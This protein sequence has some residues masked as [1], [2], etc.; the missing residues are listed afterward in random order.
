MLIKW[1]VLIESPVY[2]TGHIYPPCEYCCGRVCTIH[3][4][5]GPASTATKGLISNDA[6]CD[7]DTVF[8]DTGKYMQIFTLYLIGFILA[9]YHRHANQVVFVCSFVHSISFNFCVGSFFLQKVQRMIYMAAFPINSLKQHAIVHAVSLS[10]TRCF[11]L[12]Q[13]NG[14]FSSGQLLFIRERGDWYSTIIVCH[15]HNAWFWCKSHLFVQL[16]FSHLPKVANIGVK[17]TKHFSSFLKRE[18]WKKKFPRID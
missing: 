2:D 11:P 4:V 5:C 6:T 3:C 15:L 14:S 18:K 10:H 13:Q 16:L 17:Q 12:F 1:T 9:A 8:I 7:Y